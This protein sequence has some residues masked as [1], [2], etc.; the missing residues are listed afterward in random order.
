MNDWP[1]MNDDDSPV[2]NDVAHQLFAV[3]AVCMKMAQRASKAARFGL[4]EV[5]PGQPYSNAERIVQQYRALLSLVELMDEEGMWRSGQPTMNRV[6][7]LLW[8][9]A[10]ES[11][12][13]G[14]LASEMARFG[15]HAVAPGQPHSNANRTMHEYGDL[16]A[17]IGLLEGDG[18]LSEP[19]DFDDRIR[20]KRD[21]VE[22][23]L[24]Y[25][26]A[27]GTLK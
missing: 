20:A 10:E 16:V 17:S 22:K 26:T 7:H 12:E 6:G 4:Q 9:L 2:M 14:E 1:V 24:R 23:F 8:I 25:S 21:K 13:V 19:A 5:Q 11:M 3:A 27:C 15:L 18:V